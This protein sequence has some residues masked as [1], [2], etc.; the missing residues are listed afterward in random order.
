[1]CSLD[2]T[3]QARRVCSRISQ[4]SPADSETRT[5]KPFWTDDREHSWARHLHSRRLSWFLTA[6]LI[7]LSSLGEPKRRGFGWSRKARYLGTFTAA[8]ESVRPLLRRQTWEQAR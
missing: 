5:R 2:I 6:H 1:M 8:Y 4:S 3:A 7:H